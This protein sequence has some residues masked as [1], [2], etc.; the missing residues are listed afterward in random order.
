[1]FLRPSYPFQIYWD[2]LAIKEK[3]R[4]EKEEKARIA[5]E[6]QQEKER[7]VNDYVNATYNTYNNKPKDSEEVVVLLGDDEQNEDPAFENSKKAKKRR[8]KNEKPHLHV[9]PESSH[10]FEEKS[11]QWFK[12]CDCGFSV[13]FEKV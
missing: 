4:A 10:T 7:K 5:E 2:K 9:F 1:M 3:E 13:Q 6:R 8:K 11:K 12:K